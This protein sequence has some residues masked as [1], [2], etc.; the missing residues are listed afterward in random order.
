MQKVKKISF[1]LLIL[2]L[3]ALGGIVGN[4]YLFPHLSATRFFAKYDFLKKSAEDITYI[5]KTEQ[6][7]VKE[8]TSI[9]KI[10]NQA[11]SSVVNILSSKEKPASFKS[12]TGLIVTSDGLILTYVDALTLGAKY[13]V[14]ASNGTAY[15]ASFE[16]VDTYSNLAFLKIEATNLPA[17]SFGN[18]DDS[19]PG[20]KIIAIGNS[21]E[22]LTNRY[23]AGLLSTF[24]PTFNLSGK[25]ISYSEKMDGV[26]QTDLSLDAGP[27]YV[28]GPIV[29]Y[30]GQVIGI[31]GALDKN[32]QKT[33]FFLSSNK[34]KKV[35][36][37]AIRKELDQSVALGIYYI[38]LTRAYALSNNLQTEN[39]A[40]IFSPSSGQEG[41]AIMSGS[42]AQK[43]GLKINDI[44]LTVN[45]EKITQQK[46]LPDLLYQY[47]KGDQVQLT[48]LRNEQEMSLSVQF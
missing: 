22:S 39:G 38:P 2:I 30:T 31:N 21:S 16:G 26:F 13:K 19:R 23:A 5:N 41:L 47:K 20:E 4:R 24:N 34:V 32:G 43:A 35:M 28:G 1:L 29:D 37:K 25:A 48:L 12:G 10:S 33:F 40:L 9:E 15:E 36:E 44:I 7:Y 11:A 27:Y 18:S 8:E 6:I 3:G 42:V 14:V 46:S 17:V 45:G